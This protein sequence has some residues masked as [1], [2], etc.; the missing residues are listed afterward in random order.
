MLL[1]CLTHRRRGH[2][3]GDAERYRDRATHD[4]EWCRRDPI[5]RLTA[6]RGFDER[7]AEELR[8]R[9]HEQVER[10][11]ELARA[12]PWPD[13]ATAAELVYARG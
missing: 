7:E 11:V 4:E 3:E 8:T 1:E 5:A 12:S 2:Y 9:A 13:P 6:H 10:A